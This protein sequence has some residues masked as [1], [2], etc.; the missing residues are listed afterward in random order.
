MEN[1]EKIENLNSL[2]TDVS[3]KLSHELLK[4]VPDSMILTSCRK[5]LTQLDKDIRRI[6]M[7]RE[8]V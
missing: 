2:Y 5:Q 7:R 6:Q 1:P 8:W 3:R 4:R